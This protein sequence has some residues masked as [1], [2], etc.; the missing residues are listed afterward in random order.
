MVFV[1]LI[2][3]NTVLA[4]K[5][6]LFLLLLTKHPTINYPSTGVSAAA[7]NLYLPS[8]SPKLSHYKT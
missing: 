6:K 3:S 4:I 8:Y 5:I 1:G 2:F 7:K